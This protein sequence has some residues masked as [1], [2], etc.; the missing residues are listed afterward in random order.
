MTQYFVDEFPAPLRRGVVDV[1]ELLIA[2]PA[3]VTSWSGPRQ[4]VS[5]RAGEIC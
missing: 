2:L 3:R 5:H 4:R 1:A